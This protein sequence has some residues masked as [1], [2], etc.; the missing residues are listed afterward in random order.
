MKIM[1]GFWKFAL[2]AL[3]S[4]FILTSCEDNDWTSH[5]SWPSFYYCAWK[6]DSRHTVTLEIER[7]DIGHDYGIT[8]DAHIVIVLELKP[9]ESYDFSAILPTMPF[10]LESI[11][12]LKSRFDDGTE[13]CEVE[14]SYS[15]ENF[16]PVALPM[17]YDADH[18]VL[19]LTNY[20]WS[21]VRSPEG[22]KECHGRLFTY[23]FT[24]AD[25]AAARAWV[26][27]HPEQFAE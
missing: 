2:F 9:G 18:N 15:R 24:D 21:N 27:S 11:D 13:N 12:R 7:S 22:C 10:S 19:T 23:T 3:C 8:I 14:F 26:E 17:E 1:K 4:A 20:E 5:A 6:N 25:F 16:H